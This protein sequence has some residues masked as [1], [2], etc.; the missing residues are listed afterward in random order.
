[1]C[2]NSLYCDIGIVYIF[3]L[4]SALYRGVHF[5][6]SAR[7]ICICRLAALSAAARP[8]V[9]DVTRAPLAATEQ[10]HGC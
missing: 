10:R 9:A 7:A 2:V 3:S 1:M 4:A 8:Q 6:G 5:I